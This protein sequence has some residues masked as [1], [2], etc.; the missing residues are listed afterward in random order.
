MEK[1]DA[2]HGSE[3]LQEYRQRHQLQGV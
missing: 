2:S 3:I 1:E